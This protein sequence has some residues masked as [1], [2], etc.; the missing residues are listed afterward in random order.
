MKRIKIF[1]MGA[2]LTGL[3]LTGIPG[4]L[5]A[6]KYLHTG[7]IRAG[8]SSGISYKGY[9][10]YRESALEA[11]ILYNR[12]GFN[13]ALLLQGYF[14]LNR[15]GRFMAYAG[16]GAFG[17]DWDSDISVGIATLAGLEY[18]L[19]DLPLNLGLD[20]KPMLNIWRVTA[21]DFLDFGVSVRYRFGR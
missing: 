15:N 11:D 14:E 8:Y 13:L 5:R 3:L 1:S 10:L 9:H 6:Q 16:G 7:G 18:H 12:H 21:A 20:W 4:E 19:R 2:L 17:G